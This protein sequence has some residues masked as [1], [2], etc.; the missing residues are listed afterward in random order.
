VSDDAAAAVV[1]KH[2]SP[3]RLAAYVAAGVLLWVVLAV[4]GFLVG[5]TGTGWPTRDQ[6]LDRRESVLL[7]SLVGAALASA[8]VA[9]QAIL[10]NPL[11][12]PY[13]L[14]VSSGASLLAY[15]WRIAPVGAVVLGGLGAL[16]QQAFAFAGALLSVGVVFALSTRR[17]RL[18]PITLL[19][20]GVIV[21]AVNGS[22][23]MLVNEL[24]RGLPSMG[25]PVA[26]LVGGIQVS[27][28]RGQV[29]AAAACVAAG[30]VVLM[31]L[32]GQLNVA[33]LST[34]E[35][36][37]LGVNV[38]RLRWVALLVA[39]LVTASA[40]AISGPIGFVGLVS[41]HLARLIV[42]HDHRKL[43]PIA[44]ALGAGLL[45]VADAG[46]RLL[47]HQ[48]AA[49]TLLPVG[50]LTSLLGGPFF[51]LLLYQTRRRADAPGAVG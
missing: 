32:S 21:N 5:S 47:S 51:L 38:H 50:V 14:G 45:V 18:E 16:S 43:M 30:W 13:L 33:T 11:A 46:S 3:A 1:A 7:A 22:I 34:A 48:A 29:I 20:V 35:A 10:R 6:F 2:W 17:G 37:S 42:G 23:L 40:V 27:L 19:L 36:E 39:S 44:T 24:Y 8:G 9:Y 41:P 28:E 26:L 12:D 25:G 15:L 49:A 31:A 4:P